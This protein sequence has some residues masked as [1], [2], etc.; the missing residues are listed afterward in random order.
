MSEIDNAVHASGTPTLEHVV[1]LCGSGTCPTVY[2]TDRDTYVI[3]GY[4]VDGAKAGIDLPAGELLVEIPV[5]LLAALSRS[6]N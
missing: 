5:D 3:Q 1:T 4:P 2:R 6:D